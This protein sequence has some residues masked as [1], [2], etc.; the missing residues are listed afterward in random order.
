MV[1][2]INI[3]SHAV[4]VTSGVPQGRVLGPT[5]F[6][7]FINDVSNI[8]D[9]LDVK[10]KLFT[11]DIKLYSIY[12]VCG[13]LSNLKTAVN[14]M[15]EWSCIWQLHIATEKCFVCTIAKRSA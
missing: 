4:S 1:K 7:L 8:F 15:Y 13:S 9:E 6:L 2:L 10:L 14:R 11:D 3:Y 12:G 5:L